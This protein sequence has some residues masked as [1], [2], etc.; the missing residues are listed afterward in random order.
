M[1]QMLMPCWLFCNFFS[2]SPATPG[3]SEA[4]WLW[5]GPYFIATFAGV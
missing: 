5:A 4:E 3:L 2:L 1:I